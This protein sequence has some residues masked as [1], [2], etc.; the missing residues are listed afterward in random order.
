MVQINSKAKVIDSVV[1]Q[2][3][4]QYEQLLQSNYVSSEMRIDGQVTRGQLEENKHKTNEKEEYT[5]TC[6]CM[7]DVTINR[8]SSIEIKKDENDDDFSLKGIVLTIPNRTPVDYYFTSLLYNTEVKRYR[9]QLVYSEDGYIIGDNPLIEDSI[10]CFV[11]RIGMRERQVNVGIDRNSV[12]EIITLKKWDIQKD[13][14]L[15]IGSDK[16]IVTDIKEL[17]KDIFYGYMTYYR[18]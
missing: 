11:Q 14:I 15:H 12:N 2:A 5:R 16:Y 9:Q 13:D 7:L 10:P 18:V 4:T 3:R 8:G 17:D 6:T 1:R